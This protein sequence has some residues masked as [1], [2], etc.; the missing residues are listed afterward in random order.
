MKLTAT[1]FIY[2]HINIAG[3]DVIT[4]AVVMASKR[5]QDH[6]VVVICTQGM[7]QETRMEQEVT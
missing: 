3:I 2:T 4:L 5:S 6:P 1:V 7:E